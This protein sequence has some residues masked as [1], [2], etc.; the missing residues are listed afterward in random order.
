MEP[1]RSIDLLARESD[2]LADAATAAG[3]HAAVP[4]CPGWHVDDL[5]AHLVAGDQWACTI[6]RQNEPKRVDRVVAPEELPKGPE[7][8]ACFR[9]G[10]QALVDVLRT[11]DPT[12]SAWTFGPDRTVAFWVRRRS[13]ETS[14]HRY[15]AQ[16]AAGGALAP[17]DVALAADGVD[18]FLVVFLRRFAERT[19]D[20]GGS[21]HLHCTDVA[22]EWLLAPVDGALAVTR[23]HAKGDVAARGSAS[24]LLLWLWGRRPR[25]ELEVFGDASLLDRFRAAVAV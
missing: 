11:T 12:K 3:P 6:V 2:V 21:I 19:A 24:D 7:L 5:L 25:S 1:L 14:L 23:E 13:I 18:E 15:D 22:G 20:L 9:D 10:A 17:L 4:S 8:V 16:L